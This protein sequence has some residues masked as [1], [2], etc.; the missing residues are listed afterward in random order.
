[1]NIIKIFFYILVVMTV[2]FILLTFFNIIS[3]IMSDET[4]KKESAYSNILAAVVCILGATILLYGYS[5]CTIFFSNNNDLQKEA[6]ENNYSNNTILID[7]DYVYF[8]LEGI[9]NCVKIPADEV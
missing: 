8:K 4:Y 3:Y 6:I 9:D 7:K 5:V 1:M 2:V